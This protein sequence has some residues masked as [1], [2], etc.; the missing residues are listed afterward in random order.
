VQAK[1]ER[2][3]V[4]GIV[5]DH[6]GKIKINNGNFYDFKQQLNWIALHLSFSPYQFL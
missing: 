1:N 4:F 2:E 6:A 5:G 3:P